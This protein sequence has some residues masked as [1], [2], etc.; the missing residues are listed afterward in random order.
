MASERQERWERASQTPLLA[1][2]LAFLVAYAV[3]IIWPD[4]PDR[5]LASCEAVVVVVWV[6]FVVDLSV[7]LAVTDARVAFLR[8]NWLDVVTLLLPALRP[9]RAVLALSVI[10]R[11]GR[12]LVRGRVVAYVVGAVAVVGF[13]ASL[14]VLDAERASPDANIRTLG[15]AAWWAMTT[16]TTVGYGDKFPTTTEGR[17]VA[18]ALMVTGIAL[19]GV[20]T[21]SIASWFVEKVSEVA[22]S[23]ERTGER[24]GDLVEEVRA[25]R[26]EVARLRGSAAGERLVGPALDGREGVRVDGHDEARSE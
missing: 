16:V 21:A 18:G 10:G 6:G 23:E 3:P 17:V 7:R 24:L 9:L 11:R 12:A 8:R 22:A 26:L 20:V 15:D 13:V 5:V 2:A 25:L 19:L 14:A 1:L 4:L